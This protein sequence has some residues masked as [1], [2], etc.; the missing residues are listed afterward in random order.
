VSPTSLSHCNRDDK[1]TL[2]T[3]SYVGEIGLWTAQAFA[4]YSA[5]SS[6]AVSGPLFPAYVAYAMAISP[7]AE[8]GLI[9]YISGVPLLEKS[10]DDKFGKDPK[11]IA[12]K[13]RVPVFFPKLF[14]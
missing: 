11:W 2:V 4:S 9:R 7:L 1:L 13:E 14:G 12:Y 5:L 6:P 3:E 8:Y 10:G